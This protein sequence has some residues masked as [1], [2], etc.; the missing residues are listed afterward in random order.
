MHLERVRYREREGKKR[1][2]EGKKTSLI[3]SKYV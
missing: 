1:E 2:T 3:V